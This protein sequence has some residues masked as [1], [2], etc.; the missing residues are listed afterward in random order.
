MVAVGLV[1]GFVPSV[2]YEI[3]FTSAPLSVAPIAIATGAT[4]YQPAE[5]A[6]VLH[7]IELDGAVESACA[8]KVRPEALGRPALFSAVMEPESVPAEPVKVYTPFVFV[9]PLPNDG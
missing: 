4:V 2:V 7:V 6:A 3:D 9:Q 8:V 5:Q 1:F